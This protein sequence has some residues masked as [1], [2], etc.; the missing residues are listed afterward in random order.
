[1]QA[2]KYNVKLILLEP[3][4]WSSRNEPIIK[5]AVRKLKEFKD[6]DHSQ[7]IRELS[8]A[9]YKTTIGKVKNLIINSRSSADQTV[10]VENRWDYMEPFF[11]GS[12]SKF[13]FPVSLTGEVHLI[14]SRYY[15]QES[16]ERLE[17]IAKNSLHVHAT[18]E[19][20]DHYSM[21]APQNSMV[22]MRIALKL[23]DC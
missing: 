8:R 2:K 22:W 19:Y 10:T 13:Q 11:L 7:N 23:I 14:K 17:Q 9:F 20:M 1:M 5:K 21:A 18:P 6:R 16:F 3:T 15:N 12:V 4:L